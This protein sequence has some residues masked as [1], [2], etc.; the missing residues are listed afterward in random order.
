MFFGA[1]QKKILRVISAI[2]GIMVI[3]GMILLYM[4]MFWR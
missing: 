4:P 2:V 1:K 3:L